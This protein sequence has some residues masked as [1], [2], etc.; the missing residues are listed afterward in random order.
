MKNIVLNLEKNRIVSFGNQEKLI[1]FVVR[2]IEVDNI[3]K[4][5]SFLDI[6]KTN[7]LQ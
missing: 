1:F 3:N 4:F 7:P 5:D 6:N 2:T